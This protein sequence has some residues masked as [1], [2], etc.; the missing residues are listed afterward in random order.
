MRPNARR[1]G[2]RRDGIS[3]IELVT[4][5]AVTGVLAVGLGNLLQHPMNG[6]AAVSRR[7]ELVAL[8]D[9]ALRRLT[10][11][12][13][14]ALP[15]SVRVSGAGRALELLHTGGGGRYRLDPGVNDP[16]GPDETDHTADSD[17]LSFG[18]DDR[19]NVLGRLPLTGALPG[20]PL[21]A[22][23]RV[24]IYPTGSAIWSEAASGAN[25]G[26]ITPASTVVTI[27]DDGD[28]DQ[29]RLSA[30]H[31]FAF[32]SPSLRLFVVDTPLSYVCDLAEG[33]LWRI[34]DYPIASLQPTQPGLAPLSS[35]RAGRA[36]ERVEDCRFAYLPGTATRAGLVTVE[37]V[38]AF[39][40]ERVR[41]LHQVQVPNAP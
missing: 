20:V 41:L 5:I 3:L 26:S 40:D 23:T 13:R 19:W 11:D 29:V 32:E 35:G 9:L 16:G 21:P 1:P 25:P 2:R 15:N 36:A 34:Q 30:P 14:H 28:E 27:L 7:A 38:L 37:I 6:Y 8:A 4:V 18:G 33:A 22:G 31:R 10:R 12:V 39:A 24:A 17:W